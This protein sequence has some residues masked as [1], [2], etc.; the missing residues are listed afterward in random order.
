[1][2]TRVD[3]GRGDRYRL[4]RLL[5]RRGDDA[6]VLERA[7]LVRLL[8][9][10]GAYADLLQRDD[11]DPTPYFFAE[12]TT[13]T[14]LSDCRP[15]AVLGAAGRTRTE[16]RLA[17]TITPRFVG[18]GL[19]LAA[20]EDPDLLQRAYAVRRLGRGRQDAYRLECLGH[21]DHLFRETVEPTTC[22]SA[23]R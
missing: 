19:L 7:V 10:G 16:R 9:P 23:W 11:H 14:F 2:F 15:C 18:T 1:M 4:A 12:P 13:R 21:D 22:A 6:D 3:T 5:L 20:A 8:G 17:A